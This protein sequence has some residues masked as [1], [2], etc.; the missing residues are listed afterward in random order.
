V[1]L[2]P[3]ALAQLA[4]QDHFTGEINKSFALNPG[5]GTFS[6]QP[7]PQE[8]CD[9]DLFVF[10]SAVDEIILS[11]QTEVVAPPLEMASSANQTDEAFSNF[12]ESAS[13]VNPT[14]AAFSNISSASD[15]EFETCVEAW[16]TAWLSATLYLRQTIVAATA[17]TVYAGSKAA[18]IKQ[19][20]S[21]HLS[22]LHGVANKAIARARGVFN[23]LCVLCAPLRL[24]FHVTLSLTDMLSAI[25]LTVYE[26]WFETVSLSARLLTR[27]TADLTI[28]DTVILYVSTCVAIAA[29]S[30]T[31]YYLT[32]ALLALKAISTKL[33]KFLWK[34]FRT[35]GDGWN[36][37]KVF[38]D[39]TS[40]STILEGK[41]K[42]ATPLVVSQCVGNIV[43]LTDVN[44]ATYTFNSTGLPLQTSQVK[45]ERSI[46]GSALVAL[47]SC[48]SPVGEIYCGG[49]MVLNLSLVKS[50][51]GDSL[52]Y[53]LVTCN[54]G[55]TRAVWDD[56]SFKVRIGNAYYDLRNISGIGVPVFLLDTHGVDFT[57]VPITLDAC[58]RIGLAAS[59]AP[60]VS[61]NG[62][63]EASDQVTLVQQF[64]G[65]RHQAQG[66]L[67]APKEID[68]YEYMI[69]HTC[70]TRDGSCGSLL[71]TG[72]NAVGIHLLGNTTK[73]ENYCLDLPF[74]MFMAGRLDYEK[75]EIGNYADGEIATEGTGAGSN[76]GRKKLHDYDDLHDRKQ[77]GYKQA[78]VARG[79]DSESAVTGSP[80]S[81]QPGVS[82]ATPG[83]TAKPTKS[84]STQTAKATKSASAQTSLSSM[85][86]APPPPRPAPQVPATSATTKLVKLSLQNAE[87]ARELAKAKA[88]A[89]LRKRSAQQCQMLSSITSLQ[90]SPL[91]LPVIPEISE[92]GQPKLEQSLKRALKD[93]LPQRSPSKSLSAH[94]GTTSSTPTKLGLKLGRPSLKTLG[95]P[96]L[97]GH[98]QAPLQ[99]GSFGRGQPVRM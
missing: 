91:S 87:L 31:T 52:S 72:N 85:V 41:R 55:L 38:S 5:Q 46:S 27:P 59:L 11:N 80:V 81:F 99:K 32:K 49:K 82:L 88:L 23:F 48:K 1:I 95:G 13:S 84:A 20:F 90:R 4:V 78:M 40:P 86:Q 34:T 68:G 29:F 9:S 36:F 30:F 16:R 17:T 98:G 45:T 89:S 25:L 66:F 22:G 14:D 77:R 75:V 54:H 12:F 2:R 67:K 35:Y 37:A 21:T 15:D 6:R 69:S 19:G 63:A 43:V 33:I 71:V 64:D 83:I 60:K 58:S 73:E 3:V 26:V 18:I 47:E 70:T 50:T 39:V 7:D 96:K 62:A 28:F 74:A 92:M 57:M 24:S 94:A 44:G 42:G 10:V 65:V 76:H 51:V 8:S 97:A 79:Y 53:S 56:S 93:S 61:F